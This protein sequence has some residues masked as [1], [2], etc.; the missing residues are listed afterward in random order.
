[1]TNVLKEPYG[2]ARVLAD[3]NTEIKIT[4]TDLGLN[5]APKQVQSNQVAAILNVVYLVAGIVAVIAIV[6]GGVRYT[7]SGG[8]PSGV[9]AAKDTVLYAVVGLV[10]VI[11]A[12]AIT[13][14]VIKNVAK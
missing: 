10:V 5:D 11:M 1:M 4:P 14:F 2:V 6:I 12:A 13:D 8:D 3:A 7:V 9:K